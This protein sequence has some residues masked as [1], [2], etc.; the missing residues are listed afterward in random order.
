VSELAAHHPAPAHRTLRDIADELLEYQRVEYIDD[1]RLTFVAVPG[2]TH[3]KIVRMITR[4]IDSMWS[5]KTTPVEWD[6]RSENFQLERVDDPQKFFVPDIAVAYPGSRNNRE[7]REN[8]AMVAE[9]TSPKSP[10]TVRNDREVKPK[11]YAKAGVTCY[12]LVDQEQGSWTIYAL[13]GDW[14][15]Y[16]VHSSGRY[17]MP[18]KLP[19]PFDFAIP[20]DEW[21][22]YRE[23]G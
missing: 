22:Q 20:T 8:L 15:G 4:T 18:V 12:L 21:P 16:Q 19:E 3:A 11:Q 5:A 10:E 6:I 9:V 23:D 14:P 7:F 2:F 1:G 13:D 17:G